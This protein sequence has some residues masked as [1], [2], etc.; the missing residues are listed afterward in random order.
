MISMKSRGTGNAGGMSTFA[1]WV[2]SKM[3]GRRPDPRVIKAPYNVEDTGVW[4]V[5][6]PGMREPGST[7]VERALRA[8]SEDGVD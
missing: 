4:G 5:G 3:S 2:R 1:R 7:G 6:G 8:P